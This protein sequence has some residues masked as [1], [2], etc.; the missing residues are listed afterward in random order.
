M[1]IEA[2]FSIPD[3]TTFD[4]LC[5]L[6]LLGGLPASP[7]TIK[8]VHDRYLDTPGR[9]V[10]RGGYACRLRTNAARRLI[11]VKALTPA[12]DHLHSREEIEITLDADSTEDP[13]TWPLTEARLLVESLSQGQPL[14]LLFEAW[15]ER[16]VRLLAATVDAAPLIELSMDHVR[17]GSLD[18]PGF[19]ELEAELLD[20]S[21]LPRLAALAAELQ[22]QWRLLPEPRSKFERGMAMLA[23]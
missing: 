15:Q 2:K 8:Q 17:L 21:A 20:D 13:A 14:Q 6:A 11:T 16:H 5:A 1:E 3:Q 10:M 19:Y 7:A 12:N 18:A 4:Q 9:A 22:N 23:R